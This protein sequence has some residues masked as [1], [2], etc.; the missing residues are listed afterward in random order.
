MCSPALALFLVLTACDACPS[1]RPPAF[2][3][4]ALSWA[5]GGDADLV[6]ATPP[7]TLGYAY[8]LELEARDGGR[9]RLCRILISDSVGEECPPSDWSCADEG[10][11]ILT[12]GGG[13]RVRASFT[14]GATIEAAFS[15][16][17]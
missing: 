10:E 15:G 6:A 11:A 2:S 17:T 12:A 4:C 7:T 16:P 9:A 1:V 14:N 5:G 13:G 8:R 3:S